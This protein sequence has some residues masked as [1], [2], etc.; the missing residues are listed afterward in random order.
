MELPGIEPA[1]EIALSCGNTEFDDAKQLETTRN[2]LRIHRKVLMPSTP[3]A[4][5]IRSDN[6][7]ALV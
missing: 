2:D 1:T 5:V 3:A 4:D 7:S 6:A